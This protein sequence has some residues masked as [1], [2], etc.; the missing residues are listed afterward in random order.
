MDSAQWFDGIHTQQ[1]VELNDNHHSDDN[2]IHTMHSKL[3]SSK[4]ITSQSILSAV[5]TFNL[6]LPSKMINWLAHEPARTASVHQLYTLYSINAH[7]YY[8]WPYL[9][10]FVGRRLALM[11]RHLIC[12]LSNSGQSE[13]IGHTDNITPEYCWITGIAC[14]TLSDTHL[15]SHRLQGSIIY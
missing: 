6:P 10:L 12:F 3:N 7:L 2:Q 13:L 4:S 9:D 11:S 15:S 8:W 14:A 1:K 5:S